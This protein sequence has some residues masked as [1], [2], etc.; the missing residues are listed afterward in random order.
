MEFRS[1]KTIARAVVAAVLAASAVMAQASLTYRVKHGHWRKGC[2]GTLTVS[3]EGITF[4]EAKKHSWKWAFDDIEQ[5]ELSDKAMRVTTYKDRLLRLG[6]DQ[7]EEFIF[8]PEQNPRD[9]YE[10]LRSRLDQRFV[11]ALAAKVPGGSEIPA[12]LLGKIGGVQ[13][14]LIL[15][16]EVV[17]FQTTE[18][19]KSRTWRLSD[20]ENISRTGPFRFTIVTLERGRAQYGDRRE[21]NFQL[22]HPMPDT[23]YDAL[24]QRLN[25][26]KSL[27]ILTSYKENQQ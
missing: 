6:A 2:T 23:Q 9:A 13:G 12:K 19:G 7:Q 25:Q 14:A 26:N 15:A 8:A 17:V 11:A 1:E 18:P 21:F 20:I 27:K 22:K 16:H 4:A 24:W 3:A 5:L 10:F